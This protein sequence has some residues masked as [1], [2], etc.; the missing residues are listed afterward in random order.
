[1]T[2]LWLTFRILNWV[3][4][5]NS[6]ITDDIPMKLFVHACVIMIHIWFNFHEVLVIAH[7]VIAYF[8]HFK[9]IQGQ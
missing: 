8:M 6:C 9:S 3:K 5:D 2:K 1:M 4:G 7:L